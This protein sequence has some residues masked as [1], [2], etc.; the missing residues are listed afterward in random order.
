MT[1]PYLYLY[2]TDFTHFFAF[3]EKTSSG[4]SQPEKSVEGGGGVGASSGSG[5][6]STYGT[7]S[8]PWLP[9]EIEVAVYRA[10][11]S[12]TGSLYRSSAAYQRTQVDIFLEQLTFK[13]GHDRVVLT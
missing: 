6:T 11:G 7:T 12:G 8:A 4:Q 1:G 2:F 10:P 9:F 3:A 5:G 13:R